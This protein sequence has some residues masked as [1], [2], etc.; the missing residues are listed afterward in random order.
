[1]VR[2]LLQ[3]LILFSLSL[4]AYAQVTGVVIDSQTHKPIDFANVYYEGTT[5]GAMTDAKGRFS[6]KERDDWNELTVSTLGY[7]AQK[8][9]L[10]PGKKKN[11]KILLVGSPQQ[12]QEVTVRGRRTRYSRTRKWCS[13]LMISQRKY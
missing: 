12:I 10:V 11:L 4:G 8:V 5:T 1:M 6:V 9:R 13:R 2:Y 3:I 7:V